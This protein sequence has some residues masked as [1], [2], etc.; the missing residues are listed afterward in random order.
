MNKLN[1]RRFLQ[2]SG[3]STLGLAAYSYHRG[4]RFPALSW[5]PHGLPS[6]FQ[7]GSLSLI[8]ENLIKT[9]A[10][11]SNEAQ[12]RAYA[13]EPSLAILANDTQDVVIKVNN[14]AQ[15]AT[16]ISSNEQ[17]SESIDGITRHIKATIKRGHTLT[18][19]WRLPELGDYTFAAIGDSGG[20][21][22]LAWCLQRA[23]QLNARFLLHLGDFNYQAG[24]YDRSIELFNNSQIPCY[25]S[26]GNHDFHDDGLLHGRFLRDIGPLNHAFTIGKTRF[27]NIDT[28]ASTLPYSAGHRGTLFER[29]I[30]H[31][32]DIVDT[33]AFTHRP[34]HD[35]LPDNHGG[36]HDI[37]NTGER[38]WLIK[39][40]KDA[41]INTLISAHIHIYDRNV[42]QGIDNI[43]VGQGLG[44]Q[45]LM[46]NHD[47]SKMLIGH[48]DKSGKVD[49]DTAPLAM[50]ML[51]HCH[52]R[53]DVV[54]ES[55]THLEHYPD[56][57][58]I[59]Q[60]CNSSS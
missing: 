15:D 46:V 33:V 28:A 60:H 27:A 32:D 24:D 4:I 18:L 45:D 57:E 41:N 52:P 54:K 6:E 38:D 35:P 34:I 44:H 39:A 16:L 58:K 37:G 22:E 42:F 23:H 2:A 9:S 3:L 1:R 8:T 40:L 50:P 26:I 36:H 49:Y 17:V 21:Q 59:I 43:I 11:K 47:F 30:A 12:F 7:F 5:E 25:V 14:I 56:I 55:L 48:V 19:Q 51:M 13:P 29:L 31:Q 20:D 10:P 53:S